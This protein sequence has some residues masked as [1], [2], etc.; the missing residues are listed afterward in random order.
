MHAMVL[1]QCGCEEQRQGQTTHHEFCKSLVTQYKPTSLYQR[2]MKVLYS[3]D[4]NDWKRTG[5]SISYYKTDKHSYSLDFIHDFE[6]PDKDTYF[7]YGYPY[8]YTEN[9]A[10]FVGCI[11]S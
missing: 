1:L 3:Y 6:V 9:L 4:G 8:T 11:T 2:G 7:S 10:H 5:T